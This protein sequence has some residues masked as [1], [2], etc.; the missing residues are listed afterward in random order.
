[1][2]GVFLLPS[3]LYLL[4]RGYIAK[5]GNWEKMKRKAQRGHLRRICLL[6]GIGAW[7]LSG[8]GYRF[9]TA[10]EPVG[11]SV[12]SL[13]I[14][15]VDSTSSEPGFEGTFTRVLREE[16]LSHSRTP[17]VSEEKAAAVLRARVHHIRTSP[18]SYRTERTTVSGTAVSYHVT[19]SRWLYVKMD[20]ELIDRSSGNAVWTVRGLEDEESYTL[21]TDPL[22][23]RY[24]QERAL[25]RIAE[26]LAEKVY[27][28][29]ME[30]F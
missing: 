12:D 26:R 21:G 10:G 17:L 19:K 8:C 16:F 9:Q 24:K 7:L 14:P 23:T 15:M 2:N 18:L 4:P 25:K 5:R 6:L 30:R 22:E 11:L 13:A 3:A 20:A 1:M 28:Y 29:T 27:L